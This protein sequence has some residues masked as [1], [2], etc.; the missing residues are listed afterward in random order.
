MNC[1]V[2]LLS[3]SLLLSSLLAELIVYIGDEIG[4]QVIN[5]AKL[6]D[7]PV[8]EVIRTLNRHRLSL[9]DLSLLHFH[10]VTDPME[11]IRLPL[12]FFQELLTP[13]QLI[14]IILNDRLGV[15]LEHRRSRKLRALVGET[16]SVGQQKV[17]CLHRSIE[18]LDVSNLGPHRE[19]VVARIPTRLY[20]YLTPYVA[21]ISRSFQATFKGFKSLFD[22]TFHS[23]RE[24]AAHLK[25]MVMEGLHLL[26]RIRQ[27][28]RVIRVLEILTPIVKEIPSLIMLG[29]KLGML[30]MQIAAIAGAM[31]VKSRAYCVG[32]VKREIG[33]R[34][35][36]EEW[37][38]RL[39]EEMVEPSMAQSITSPKYY[40]TFKRISSVL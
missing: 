30:A 17:K 2:L 6:D 5:F 16:G 23:L 25:A 18:K 28:Q 38:D 29:V 26:E 20:K 19:A 27:D 10:K 35:K 39:Y 21:L 3:L 12:I 24:L 37:V 9:N 31:A 7:L 40:K 13:E 32:G 36:S 22:I 34:G 4:G 8:M 11:L 14:E 33:D 15:L 1:K